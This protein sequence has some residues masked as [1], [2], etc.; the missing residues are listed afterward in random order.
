M[1]HLPWL[2]ALPF[3]PLGSRARGPGE[4]WGPHCHSG[5]PT[6]R[7]VA[8]AVDSGGSRHLDPSG[9]MGQ[10]VAQPPTLLSLL[11]LPGAHPHFVSTS[12]THVSN[13]V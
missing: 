12:A 4:L 6:G 7:V 9:F 11:F 1:G 3:L 5:P 13:S 10:T 2:T 8:R